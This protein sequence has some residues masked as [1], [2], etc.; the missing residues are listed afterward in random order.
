MPNGSDPPPYLLALRLEGEPALVVGGG[1][2][3]ARKVAGLVTS[4][5]VVTVVAPRT[6][7]E[8][9]TLA[10]RVLRRRYRK[11][12]VAGYR[13]VVTASGDPAVDGQ[14]YADAEAAGILVNAADNRDA[15]RFYV[16][17]VLRRGP[18]SVAVSTGG[19]SPLLASWLKE[20]IAEAFGNEIG[21]LAEVLGEARQALLSA[22]L[23]TEGLPWS[24]LLDSNLVAALTAGRFD[25]AR[26]R[27]ASFVARQLQ[28]AA[29]PA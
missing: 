16:P 27:A 2:V 21:A 20:R 18:V 15:C 11:G 3:A 12:D 14:V 17:A 22:G 24:E 8:V 1:R 13:I 26:D 4:G 5:A 19:T 6:L 7:T 28:L 23:H 29:Q 9:D 10:A 25:E